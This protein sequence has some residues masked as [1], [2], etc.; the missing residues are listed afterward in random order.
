[1]YLLANVLNHMVV[2]HL[3]ERVFYTTPSRS[4]DSIIKFIM[5]LLAMISYYS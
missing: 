5:I 3:T 4:C 2:E 1:M